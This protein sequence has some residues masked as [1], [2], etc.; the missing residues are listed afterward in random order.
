MRSSSFKNK[1]T[2]KLF[3]YKLHIYIY[4]YIYIYIYIYVYKQ[5]M[6]LNNP[7]ELICHKTAK[8]N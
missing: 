3:L 5:Y 7:K 8:P 4:T 6:A 1:V 2:H